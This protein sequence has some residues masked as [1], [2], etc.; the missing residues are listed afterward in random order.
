VWFGLGEV[1]KKVVVRV[2]FDDVE[3]TFEGNVEEVWACVSKV[4][5]ESVPSFGVAKKLLLSVDL[6]KLAEDCEGLIAFSPEGANLL[7]SKDKLTDNE[8]LE[9]WL[10]AAYVGFRLG[11]MDS[12]AVSKEYLQG[13]LGKNAKIVSTRLGELVKNDLVAKTA[14]EKYKMTTFGV[15]QMQ[16]DILPKIRSKMVG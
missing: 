14:D 5:L 11:M 12:E 1:G 10:L 4:L 3:Q 9:L 7:V 15:V 16:K 6:Q 13:K 2:K 8:T